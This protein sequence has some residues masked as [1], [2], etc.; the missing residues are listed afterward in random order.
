MKNEDI[1]KTI[2]REETI[3]DTIKKRKLRLFG[4]ICK[5][6]DNRLIKHTIFARIDGKLRKRLSM[7]R[8]ARRHQEL[9]WTQ[10]TGSAPPGTRLMDVEETNL[11]SGWPQWAISLRD[12]MNHE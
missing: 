2:A 3:I 4:H 9:V 6:N 8:M 5:M 1:R 7:Q 12:I 11:Y 10:R